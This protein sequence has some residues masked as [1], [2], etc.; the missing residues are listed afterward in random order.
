MA[1]DGARFS[2]CCDS[3]RNCGGTIGLVHA[4]LEG[5]KNRAKKNEAK[6]NTSEE[7]GPDSIN[8]VKVTILVV[9]NGIRVMHTEVS[10]IPRRIYL[11]WLFIGLAVSEWAVEGKGSRPS[12]IRTKGA[13]LYRSSPPISLNFQDIGPRLAFQV[14]RTLYV[15]SAVVQTFRFSLL[16]I[17]SFLLHSLGNMEDVRMAAHLGYCPK[18]DAGENL[19]FI[20]DY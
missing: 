19:R 6:R 13:N 2:K 10:S 4:R 12:L 17:Y 8:Q 3:A 5:T 15:C 14:L 9:L 11:L 18:R 16:H 20:I 7:S 1:T